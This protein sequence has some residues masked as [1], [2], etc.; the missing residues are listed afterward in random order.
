[1]KAAFQLIYA[2]R[3]VDEID[4]YTLLDILRI[5]RE[6]NT[7]V[8]VTGVLLYDQQTFIQVLE[9][10]ERDVEETFQRI[11]H[12]NR[13]TDVITISTFNIPSR[14]FGDWSM[15]FSYVSPSVPPFD[16]VNAFFHSKEYLKGISEG[17]ARKI[18]EGFQNGRWRL[19]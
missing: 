19:N 1:M 6:R 12:D 16:E 17:R 9:G 4:N 14:Q 13:H 7:E 11:T 18:L 10:E 5:S 3:A 8:G 2:S 15:G